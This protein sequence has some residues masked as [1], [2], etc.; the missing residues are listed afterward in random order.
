MNELASTESEATLV[1]QTVLLGDGSTF[2][3]GCPGTPRH[4]RR[5]RKYVRT[6]MRTEPAFREAFAD[7]YTRRGAPVSIKES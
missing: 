3:L 1:N 4:A 2:D 6:R 5:L 7:Q